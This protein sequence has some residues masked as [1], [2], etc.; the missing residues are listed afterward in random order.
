[1]GD[2]DATVDGEGGGQVLVEAVEPRPVHLIHQLSHTD[3]L[4]E[5]RREEEEEREGRR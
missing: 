3:H 2:A 1:M 4:W 5:E